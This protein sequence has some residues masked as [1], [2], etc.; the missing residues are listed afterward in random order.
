MKYYEAREFITDK[1]IVLLK[2]RLLEIWP[3]LFVHN[4]TLDKNV[5]DNS[6][7]AMYNFYGV[8][9]NG[10]YE[11]VSNPPA[12]KYKKLYN[13]DPNNHPHLIPMYDDFKSTNEPLKW[14]IENIP[15]SKI[16]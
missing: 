1:F 8:M 12:I 14:I 10:L 13:T 2:D 9:A 11:L 6:N 4:T 7:G 3:D 5:Y 15:T 16:Y